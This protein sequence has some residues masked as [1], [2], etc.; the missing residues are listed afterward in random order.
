MAKLISVKEGNTNPVRY[1][2]DNGY[3]ACSIIGSYVIDVYSIE[4]YKVDSFLRMHP[5]S[6]AEVIEIAEDYPEM[7]RKAK[8]SVVEV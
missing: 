7:L 1:T 8:A 3:T 4:G 6:Q 2:A 5:V